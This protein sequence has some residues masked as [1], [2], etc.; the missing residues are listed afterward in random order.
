MNLIG[1]LA[2][3]ALGIGLAGLLEYLDTSLRT[4]DDVVA[5]VSLPV[6]A[7]IPLMVTTA[8]ERLKLRGRWLVVGSAA[9]AVALGTA[10]LLWK[11]AS[12]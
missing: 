3:L 1:A 10:A 6:L 12:H 7:M 5:A 9:A 8:E 2:G 11:V 4:D